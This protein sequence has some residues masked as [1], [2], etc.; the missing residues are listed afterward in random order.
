MAFLMLIIF[1]IVL[2]NKNITTVYVISFFL[3]LFFN[4]QW[5]PALEYGAEIA[6]PVGEASSAGI[7]ILGGY[8][9]GSVWS[10]LFT[11]AELSA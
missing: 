5:A 1:L 8:T 4:T 9:T 3:G 11:L 7:L 6:Y 2:Q 10:C